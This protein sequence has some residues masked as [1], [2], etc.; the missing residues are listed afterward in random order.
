MRE[1]DYDCYLEYTDGLSILASNGEHSSKE[2]Y[3]C[4]LHVIDDLP[5]GIVLSNEFIFQNRFFSRLNNISHGDPVDVCP[6]AAG[7][8]DSVLF[9]R[10]RS[11]RLSMLS[12]WR[13]LLGTETAVE[14]PL[15]RSQHSDTSTASGSS[16]LASS[17]N[18]RWQAE[19]ARRNR[20]QRR[21]TFLPEPQKSVEQR[22]ED[23]R[24]VRWDRKNPRPPATVSAA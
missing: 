10:N 21:I 6:D 12:Q 4:D 19:E 13:R 7:L 16:T 17:R 22:S 9:M 18:G 15:H 3:I 5:C 11:A 14:L 24:R 1:L 2:S 8:V 20:L 23:H